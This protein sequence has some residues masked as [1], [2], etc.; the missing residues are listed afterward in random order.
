MASNQALNFDLINEDPF[1]YR[2]NSA[3]PDRPPEFLT[4]L[5]DCSKAHRKLS[6]EATTRQLLVGLRN[7][8]RLK[9]EQLEMD[10]REVAIS[11]LTADLEGTPLAL[12]CYTF[13]SGSCI[14][15]AVTWHRTDQGKAEA[16][17]AFNLTPLFQL[18]SE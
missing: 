15:D 12:S 17:T 7:L 13:R 6:A 4:V 8:V 2:L 9:Q 14:I 3:Q 18:Q 11:Y 5:S 10:G 1:V 16:T